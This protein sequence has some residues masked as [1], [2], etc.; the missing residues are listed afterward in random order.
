MGGEWKECF[1]VVFLVFFVGMGE[2]ERIGLMIL[3]LRKGRDRGVRFVF[4][5]GFCLFV[6]SFLFH[7]KVA[8]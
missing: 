3:D 4:M 8:V 5:L 1:C 6:L 2:E 7:V